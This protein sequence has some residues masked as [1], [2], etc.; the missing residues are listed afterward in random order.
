MIV[1]KTYS[2]APPLQTP[3]LYSLTFPEPTF[4]SSAKPPINF[5][6]MHS[7][8][9]VCN[10]VVMHH[11]HAHGFCAK[12]LSI[13]KITNMAEVRNSGGYALDISRSLHM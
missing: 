11:N 7:N 9:Y 12:S 2:S 5:S 6:F 1:N 3:G 4:H 8:A 10:D 13:L